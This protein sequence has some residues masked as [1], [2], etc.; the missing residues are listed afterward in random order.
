MK[1]KSQVGRGLALVGATMLMWGT[2]IGAHTDSDDS[3]PHDS[4]ETVELLREDRPAHAPGK[5]VRVLRV[6]FPPKAAAAQHHHTG[7]VTV[8][9]LKGALRSQLQGEEPKIY[10]AGDSFFEPAGKAHLIAENPSSTD[11]AVILAVHLDD[12][13]AVPTVFHD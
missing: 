7:S 4:Q 8:I 9:V 3:K 6:T 1:G 12:E 13:G 5:I 11:Q 2:P 10:E